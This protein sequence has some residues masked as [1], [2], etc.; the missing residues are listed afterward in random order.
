[1]LSL[2]SC[3][4]ALNLKP[5]PQLQWHFAE[6]ITADKTHRILDVD[7]FFFSYWR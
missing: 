2:I 4:V 6:R 5:S 7:G 1:M 3:N